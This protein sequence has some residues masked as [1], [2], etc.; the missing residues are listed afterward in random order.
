LEPKVTRI[1]ENA[2][3]GRLWRSAPALATGIDGG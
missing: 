3:F 2:R 1:S